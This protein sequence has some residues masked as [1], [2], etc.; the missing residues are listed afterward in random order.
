MTN[1]I[2][3]IYNGYYN[4]PGIHDQ[5]KD[6]KVWLVE[7]SEFHNLPDDTGIKGTILDS[8]GKLQFYMLTQKGMLRCISTPMY[9]ELH[10]KCQR[11]AHDDGSSRLHIDPDYLIGLYDEKFLGFSVNEWDRRIIQWQTKEEL[12]IKQEKLD[13]EKAV[14]AAYN[15]GKNDVLEPFITRAKAGA[16]KLTEEQDLLVQRILGFDFSYNYTDDGSVWR[17]WANV[18]HEIKEDSVRLGFGEGALMAVSV[19]VHNFKWEK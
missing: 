14:R 4:Y 11:I 5:D 1:F 19:F 3:F 9:V 2:P 10:E 6:I 13:Q 12:R 8:E 18:E 7:E 15:K 17:H 16:D